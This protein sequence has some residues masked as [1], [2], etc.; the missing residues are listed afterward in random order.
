[1]AWVQAPMMN[2]ARDGFASVSD[3]VHIYVFGGSILPSAEV[4]DTKSKSWNLLPQMHHPRSC[5]SCSLIGSEVFVVGGLDMCNRAISSIEVF[6][7]VTHSWSVLETKSKANRVGCATLSVGRCLYIFGGHTN[8]EVYD[9]LTKLWSSFPDCIDEIYSLPSVTLI[10]KHIYVVGGVTQDSIVES[11]RI[12]SLHTNQ[13]ACHK[14][15]KF[16]GSCGGTGFPDDL[17]DISLFGTTEDRPTNTI[18]VYN[19]LELKLA[20]TNMPQMKI[21]RVGC[22]LVRVK[23]CLYAIGGHDG[24][25]MLKSMEFYNLDS[26]KELAQPETRCH[27]YQEEDNS[28]VCVVCLESP[29]SFAF[30][31]CG[32]L[33]LCIT[34][35]NLYTSKR[36]TFSC[37]ICRGQSSFLMKIYE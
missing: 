22:A 24:I 14:S 4:F 32:H 13:W 9:T 29:R 27:S 19:P 30:V 37:V 5:A 15:E 12:Y 21:K 33:S 20:S 2:H 7:V 17:K 8:V 36:R 35:A 31:P 6:N 1:M 10:G 18:A 28:N 25:G 11:V 26:L 16:V 34:C 23:E 3:G